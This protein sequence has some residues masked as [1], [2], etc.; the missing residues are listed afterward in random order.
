[1][2]TTR[3]CNSLLYFLHKSITSLKKWYKIHAFGLM[4]PSTK[5]HPNYATIMQ[6]ELT[7]HTISFTIQKQTDQGAYKIPS[8]RSWGGEMVN[9]KN[10]WF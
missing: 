3:H 7:A 5:E 6:P 4:I 1:M 9:K 2:R 8:P 10:Y